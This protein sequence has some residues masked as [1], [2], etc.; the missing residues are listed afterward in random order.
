MH[1]TL[2]SATVS[3]VSSVSK[4]GR[5][6]RRL[7]VVTRL[8][9]IETIVL[10]VAFALL[11]IETSNAVKSA[12]ESSIRSNLIQQAN[13]FV[14]SAKSR[15]ATVPLNSFV[16]NYLSSDVLPSGEGVIIGIN[17]KAVFATVSA[18]AVI[19]SSQ[20][21]DLIKS[22]PNDTTFIS[23]TY[24]AKQYKALSSPMY[25]ANSLQGVFIALQ[26][27][28]T[29][30]SYSNH[31]FMVFIFQSGIVLLLAIAITYILLRRVLKILKDIRLAAT[32]ISR[33]DLERRIDMIGPNDELTLVAKT[34]DNM[35]DR[36]NILISDQKRL[37]SDVSHQLKTPL[38]AM[39]GQLDLV[40]KSNQLDS[41]EVKT[42]V[43]S[44]RNEIDRASRLV[45]QLLVLGRS[46]EEVDSIPMDLRSSVSEIL[47]AAIVIAQ[48]NWV[49]GD[50][51]DIVLN[52]DVDK[53]N[54]AMLN[55]V[56]NAAKAT[57]VGDTI[58]IGAS[59]DDDSEFISIYVKDSGRGM[60]ESEIDQ[61]FERFKKGTSSNA[62]TGLGLNIVDSV[63]RAHGGFVR[64]ESEVGAGTKVSIVIP[65]WRKINYGEDEDEE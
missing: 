52:I 5:R 41:D 56:D 50:V 15:S 8:M 22:P 29:A 14:N 40:L 60:S 18:S 37:L 4:S 63:A 7:T 28:S 64:L 26:D 17:S 32:D 13:Q 1:L 34:F 27:E 61:A 2:F 35:I 44:V 58:E 43:Q 62:G 24:Q 23:F 65:S 53:F 3:S 38:T 47:N 42:V 25:E 51:P 57:N 10:L 21:T 59:E 33:G 39:G 45:E 9:L 12:G 19:K 55:L 31:V 48:R 11:S 30:V 16:K 36:I 54:S 49:K 46:I 6:R 20:V